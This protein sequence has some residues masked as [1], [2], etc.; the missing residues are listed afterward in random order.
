MSVKLIFTSY[1]IGPAFSAKCDL[2]Y[3]LKSNVIYKYKC[4]GCNSCYIGE[5]TRHLSSRIDEYLKK[6][7]TSHIYKHIHKNIDCFISCDNACFSI[8]YTAPT[9]FQL[10]LKEGLH[11]IWGNPDLNEQVKYISLCV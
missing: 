8:L 4:A 5:T 10:K 1:K 7:S 2:Q 3:N 9:N 6:N 11:I